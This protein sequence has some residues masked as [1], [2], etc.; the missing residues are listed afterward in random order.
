MGDEKMN[1]KGNM[2]LRD[3]MFM[4]IIF[5]AV[6]LL[7]GLF[8]NDIAGTDQ[9][10]NAQM[11]TDYTGEGSI[12]SV[13]QDLFEETNDSLETM[14]GQTDTA[15]GGFG[16]IVG[17]IQGVGTILSK[18]ITLPFLIKPIL[19]SIGTGIGLPT[20]VANVLGNTIIFGI[21]VIIIFVIISALSRGGTKL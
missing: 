19:A 7:I 8:V 10:D 5:S 2:A 18:I 17:T 11:I 1:K 3:I 4:L 9:Y 6:L 21:Y 13:G 16:L 15:A 14:Y 12:G 20:S